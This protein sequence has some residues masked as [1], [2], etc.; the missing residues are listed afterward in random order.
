MI[1]KIL[2]TYIV[3]NINKIKDLIVLLIIQRKVIKLIVI[4]SPLHSNGSIFSL[5]KIV[6]QVSIIFVML[7]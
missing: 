3:K 4:P 6:L 5:E 7:L 2:I 1:L